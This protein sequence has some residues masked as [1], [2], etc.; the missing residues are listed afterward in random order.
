MNHCAL[1]IDTNLGKER[2]ETRGGVC[3]T[4]IDPREQLKKLTCQLRQRV[5]AALSE[6]EQTTNAVK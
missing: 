3:E 2:K 4:A 6:D 5:K 1:K